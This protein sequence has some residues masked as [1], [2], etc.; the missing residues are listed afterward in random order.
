MSD[1]QNPLGNAL[2]CQV[3]IKIKYL[4]LCFFRHVKIPAVYG[5][6]TVK[7]IPYLFLLLSAIGSLLWSVF[8]FATTILCDI[9]QRVTMFRIVSNF[10]QSK[11][12]NILYNRILEINL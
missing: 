11:S 4:C 6:K 10:T 8:F 7:F 9:L 5:I 12:A 2:W 1:I 3:E